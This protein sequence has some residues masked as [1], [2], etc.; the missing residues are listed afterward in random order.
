[1]S[2]LTARETNEYD[3]NRY[4]KKPKIK[5][6][7]FIKNNNNNFNALQNSLNT[8]NFNYILFGRPKS[9]PNQKEHI[10]RIS[11]RNNK[12]K[13]Q[14]IKKYL[15]YQTKNIIIKKIFFIVNHS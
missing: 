15:I 3:R 10:K 1:M 8:S 5:Y 9:L 11:N 14:T 2:P 7:S 4:N 13:I 12:K 6:T